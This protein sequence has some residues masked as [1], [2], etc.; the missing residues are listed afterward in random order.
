MVEL[1]RLRAAEIKEVVGEIQESDIA[2]VI[3]PTTDSLVAPTR[4]KF[5]DFIKSLRFK[6]NLRPIIL[7]YGLDDQAQPRLHPL[8]DSQG[9][10]KTKQGGRLYAR[11]KKYTASAAITGTIDI[12]PKVDSPMQLQDIEILVGGVKATGGTLEI[13][14]LTGS[15]VGLGI[16]GSYSASA[17][18]VMR[19]PAPGE[20][21][22]ANAKMMDTTHL[23]T[24]YNDDFIRFTLAS[25]ANNEII[26]IRQRWMIHGPDD[27]PAPTLAANLA[28]ANE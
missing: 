27:P 3:A 14:K 28:E 16:W 25:M 1:R 7:G 10:V 9:S 6:Y 15:G 4:P 11:D 18:N 23:P 22:T 8:F 12:K 17:S 5:S 21:Q 24:V 2:A 20:A 13:R 26:T 19:V